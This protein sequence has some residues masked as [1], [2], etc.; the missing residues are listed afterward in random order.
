MRIMESYCDGS[1]HDDLDSV[2][3]LTEFTLTGVGDVGLKDERVT[4]DLCEECARKLIG[5]LV[6]IIE[7]IREADLEAQA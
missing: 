5:P 6:P 7:A 2:A 3:A 4:L 1:D